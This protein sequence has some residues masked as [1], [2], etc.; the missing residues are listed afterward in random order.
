MR[1]YKSYVFYL[2]SNMVKAL[3]NKKA[4]VKN[5]MFKTENPIKINPT[6]QIKNSIV[7]AVLFFIKQTSLSK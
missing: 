1:A 7:T 4:T 6:A 2:P 3:N 5:T